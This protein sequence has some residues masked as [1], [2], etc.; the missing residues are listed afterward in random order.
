MSPL[1]PRVASSTWRLA[2]IF[3][4]LVSHQLTSH[5]QALSRPAFSIKGPEAIL[6]FSSSQQLTSPE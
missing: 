3:E 6:V 1:L 4:C 5:K 2:A